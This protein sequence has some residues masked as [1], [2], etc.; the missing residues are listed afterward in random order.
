[1]T[2]FPPVLTGAAQATVITPGVGP[3]VIA[4]SVG[5]VGTV[6][7]AVAGALAGPVPALFFVYTRKLH[8]LTP[9]HAMTAFGAVPG[10]YDERNKTNVYY[11][12]YFR[13]M[14]RWFEQ[15]AQYAR[16]P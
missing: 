5:G 16:L 15:N 10:T 14:G 9:V 1:M 12:N 11:N 6:H 7:V 2:A 8:E 4:P 3:P 13:D